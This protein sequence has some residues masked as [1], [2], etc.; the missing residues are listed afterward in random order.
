MAEWTVIR[1][2][3]IHIEAQQHPLHTQAN[4]ELA[5]EF[6][7]QLGGFCATNG[8]ENSVNGFILLLCIE[9]IKSFNQTIVRFI[10][11][12]IRIYPNFVGDFFMKNLI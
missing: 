5:P 9:T 11:S 3:C 1:D 2:L 8:K 10:A 7:E 12:Y 6:G 4:Y